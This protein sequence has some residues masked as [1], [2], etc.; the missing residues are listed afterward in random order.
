MLVR[1]ARR[2]VRPAHTHTR[3]CARAWR[4]SRDE[5]R[6]HVLC[7]SAGHRNRRGYEDDGERQERQERGHEQTA[8]RH[9]RSTSTARHRFHGVRVPFRNL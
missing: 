2:G 1:P 6:S 7:A 3:A 9:T 4:Q 8:T 5:R